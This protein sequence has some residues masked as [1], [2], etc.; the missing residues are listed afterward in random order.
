MV[1]IP[2]PFLPRYL[3]MNKSIGVLGLGIIGSVWARQYADVIQTASS[4]V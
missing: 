4:R 1:L 3:L 2:C